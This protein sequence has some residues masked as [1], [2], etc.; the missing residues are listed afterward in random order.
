MS[1]NIDDIWPDDYTPGMPPKASVPVVIVERD[2]YEAMQQE[3][4]ALRAERDQWQQRAEGA[5]YALMLTEPHML[6]GNMTEWI[7]N[8]AQMIEAQ[9]RRL[10][11]LERAVVWAP[12]EDGEYSMGPDFAPVH[13]SCN[14][15][16]ANTWIEY[17]GSEVML[18]MDMAV[19]RRIT[20]EGVDD[21][22]TD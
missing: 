7:A 15:D 18:P 22:T 6:R 1:D 3:L 21:A 12:V 9:G 4:D 8:C 10:A 16:A 20:Q 13:I 17:A 5:V 14:R 19:F 11:E 2:A